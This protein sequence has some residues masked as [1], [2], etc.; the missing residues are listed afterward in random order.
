[1]PDNYA[2]PVLIMTKSKGRI[3]DDF[4]RYFGGYLFADQ[5]DLPPVIIEIL[6][7]DK[8]RIQSLERE[9]KKGI[10]K[11]PPTQE[12]IEKERGVILEE[13]NMYQDTP[14]YQIGWNFENLVFGDQP[15]G[16]DQIGT[17]ELIKKVSHDDF[18]KYK[19]KLYLKLVIN[20]GGKQT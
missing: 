15:L 7:K 1:M 11:R 16:W 9:L 19:G 20:Y 8:T 5:K 2:K 4:L 6:E 12:E 3:L 14:M 10:T 18:V 17:K 13:Y